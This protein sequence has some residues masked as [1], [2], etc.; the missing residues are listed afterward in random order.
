M[1]DINKETEATVFEDTIREVPFSNE[2]EKSVIG[3]MF[4]ERN[5]IPDVI[6]RVKASDFYIERHAELYSTIIELYDMGKPIDLITLE[7]QL[8][9]RG[10]LEK[11]GGIKF[12]V[13]VINGV[14]SPE[15]VIYYAN[16]VK[17]KAVLRKLIKLSDKISA[18]CYGGNKE[19]DD[20]LAEA[21]QGIIDISADRF[22]RGLLPIGNYLDEEVEV[23]DR[24]S[25]T[26]GTI[27]GMPT[28]FKD[29]DK[30]TSGL[31]KSEL[32]IIAGRPGMGKSSFALNIA[33]NAAVKYK[34]NVAI[35][36]LEMPGL[37]IANRLL[38]AE[39]KISSERLKTGNLRDDDWGKLAEATEVLAKSGIYVDDTSSITVSEVAARARKLT[40]EKGLDL[41]VIDYLQLMEGADKKSRGG[42]NRQNQISAITRNLKILANDLKIP[43]IVL[44]QLSRSNDKEKREPVLSDLRDSGSIEQDA[45]IV[46][47]L[48]REGYYKPDIEQP[49]KTKCN[50]AKYRQGETGDINLTWLGEYTSFSDWSGM[51]E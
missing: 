49:N 8:L 20:I 13:D 18:S 23:L 24:L 27:T 42:E 17:D 40:L 12:A 7:E 35:F 25:K 45:D 26:D 39:A 38:S 48:H 14:P 3:A 2:A 37:Q 47:F 44:S 22:D 30:K 4:L 11:I 31:H 19:T 15:S 51:S 46:V 16:I 50:F 36:S 28:G 29:V 33:Q 1:S 5:C 6:E 41:I 32:V 10:S 34:K 9:F 21:Q 43:V